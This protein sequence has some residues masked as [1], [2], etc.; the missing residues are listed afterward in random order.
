MKVERA[1]IY[2][3]VFFTVQYVQ[4]ESGT[5]PVRKLSSDSTIHCAGYTQGKVTHDRFSSGPIGDGY[6]NAVQFFEYDHGFIRHM[7]CTNGHYPEFTDSYGYIEWLSKDT[8]TLNIVQLERREGYC[9]TAGYEFKQG[10][11]VV[12]MPTCN[13]EPNSKGYTDV[14]LTYDWVGDR[15]SGHGSFKLVNEKYIP[16]K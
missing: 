2:I 7:N 14:V 4:A 8:Q 10:H 5:L 9:F 16:K 13:F 6:Y 11:L 15:K 3:F 12:T 1:I